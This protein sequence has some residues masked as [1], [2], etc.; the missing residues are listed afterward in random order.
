MKKILCLLLLCCSC[1]HVRSFTYDDG[2]VGHAVDC[3]DKK[4]GTDVCEQIAGK[5]CG[6][7]RPVITQHNGNYSYLVFVCR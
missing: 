6:Y 3:E 2:R 7:R 4:N 5:I 1:V